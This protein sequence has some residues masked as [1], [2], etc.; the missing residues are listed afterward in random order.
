MET[1]GEERQRAILEDRCLR[2]VAS[3]T[4]DEMEMQ[5]DMILIMKWLKENKEDKSI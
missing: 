1:K 2:K 3:M 5:Q 4:V